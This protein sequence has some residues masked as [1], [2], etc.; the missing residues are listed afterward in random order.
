[1]SEPERFLS[2][3]TPLPEGMALPRR[4]LADYQVESC[5][6][7]K[8]DGR[9][10][11]RLRRKS[12]GKLVILKAAPADREDLAEEFRILTALAPLL[13]GAVPEPVDCFEEGGTGYLLRT[14]LEGETLAQRREREGRCPEET[15]IALGQK[16]C[17]LL[18]L[19][20]RQQPPVIYRDLKPENIILLPDGGVGLIDFGIAR[21]FHN[22]KDTDTRNMGTRST[23]APEQ[24]G[25]AQTDQRTDL[26]ALGM[27]LIWLLTGQYDRDAL[28]RAEGISPHLR[29]T[30]EKAAAFS[31]EDR[32][33]DAAAFS[34]AL[35]GRKSRRPLLWAAALAL[36]AVAAVGI[37]VSLSERPSQPQPPETEPQTQV[38]T[39]AFASRSMEAAVRQ[40]LGQAEGEI[41][42]NQLAQI[43][44]L[45]AVGE[46]TFGPEQTFDY[47]IGCYID[48]QFQWELPP[49]D[50]TDGDLAL[51]AHMP[52]LRELYLC[53]Q[54]ITDLSALEGLPL[55]TL[56][57]CENQIADFSTLASLTELETLYL[58]GNPGSDYSPLSG[59]TGLETLVVEGSAG[60]GVLAAD[61]LA[62]LDGL[63]PRRLGLGLTVPRDGSWAPL[64]R[65]VA[66][67]ELQLWDPGEEA[68]AAATALTGL[69]S[70][71]IGDYR[72]ADLTALAGMSGLEVLNLHKGGLERLDGAET[73]TG[74]YTLSL[75]F[76]AVADLS[77]L[78]GLPRLNYVQLEELA[79]TDFSPLNQLPALGVVV[80]PQAQGAAVE[81]ACPGHAFE[82]RTY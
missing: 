32:F 29:R 15:C 3:F 76:S 21:R 68:V 16:M 25:Y 73:L 48:N 7:H 12:D 63:T 2:E 60:S 79:V 57:L 45:A 81:A 46:N 58:G 52:N 4:I 49:G 56:A 65:Q 14:Y 23:A 41:T 74:L 6:G 34:A 53:R 44:R 80:V 31:P 24:Y 42:Y 82:L 77:P 8:E 67:E 61:S 19:L 39:V 38:Q 66:L 20:H 78:E 55:T 51:L 1:M 62:F 70:L 13:P 9:L 17:A 35:A 36:A 30:L 43:Q 50:I 33:Q 72:A 26:Y 18:E 64:A 69:K 22:G 40:A 71:F 54:E 47:R 5:L 37:G 28:A 59:L 10:I 27:T 11:L 75:G